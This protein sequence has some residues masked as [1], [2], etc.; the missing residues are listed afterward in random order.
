MAMPEAQQNLWESWQFKEG[1]MVSTIITKPI[2][3]I[4]YL[5]IDSTSKLQDDATF[6]RFLRGFRVAKLDILRTY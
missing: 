1:E 5:F 4:G 2:F 3:G 6:A